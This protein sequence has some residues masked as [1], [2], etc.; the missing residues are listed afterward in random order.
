M[1]DLRVRF[2]GLQAVDGATFDVGQ[3]SMTALIGPNGAG[4]TTVFNLLTGFIRADSGVVRFAG[5]DIF[6]ERP[7][8]I[9]RLGLV[10]T[11]QLTKVLSKMTV[12]DNVMLA[13]PDQ[14]GARLD[15][16]VFRR[17]W[18]TRE[19]E[20]RAEALELLEEVG[21]ATHAGAYAATLSGGQKKL[22]ELARALMTRPRL[23]LLDEPMAGVN[24]TLGR[25]L[26]DYLGRLRAERGLTILFVEHD[27]ETVMGASDDVIVMAEGAVISRGTPDHVRT[28]PRVIDAYLGAEPTHA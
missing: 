17:S 13:A 15:R 20:V 4:K 25:R 3:G 12:L 19:D 9:A 16:A 21:I 26:L 28:D 11:F 8:R 22:L 7:D 5:H 2:G 6:R 18:R 24:P 14:P 10:R 1:R 23:V 27:M